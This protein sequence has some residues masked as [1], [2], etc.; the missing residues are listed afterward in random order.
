[1]K[2]TNGKQTSDIEQQ[3][4][5]EMHNFARLG[6]VRRVNYALQGILTTMLPY[7][8]KETDFE[9]FSNEIDNIMKPNISYKAQAIGGTLG[10]YAIED[11]ETK[12]SVPVEKGN[13]SFAMNVFREYQYQNMNKKLLRLVR[14]VW[15]VLQKEGKFNWD[16]VRS[17]SPYVRMA[18]SGSGSDTDDSVDPGSYSSNFFS[19]SSDGDER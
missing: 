17:P 4:L 15:R 9:E 6:D 5:L 14:R 8:D 2:M 18:L 10:S 16:A 7:L 12:L 13:P 3:I 11:N 19:N 1:M